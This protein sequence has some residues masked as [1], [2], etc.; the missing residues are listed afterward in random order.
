MYFIQPETTLVHGTVYCP[1]DKCPI[2]ATDRLTAAGEGHQDD[3]EGTLQSPTA[4][5]GSFCC[6][7]QEDTAVGSD[8]CLHTAGTVTS[9]NRCLIFRN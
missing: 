1:E 9:G 2:K 6:R 3:S 5:T 4:R 7:V 8:D